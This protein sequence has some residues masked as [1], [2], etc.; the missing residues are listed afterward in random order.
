MALGDNV[1]KS[2]KS[3]G[4]S[5]RELAERTDTDTSY[6]N[7]VETGKV[8]PSVAVLER[9]AVALECSLDQLVKGTEEPEVEIRD[10]GLADR[11]RLIDS[12]DEED[13]H[14][15]VHMIDTMLTKK[16]MR[17][18]LDGQLAPTGTEG[19]RKAR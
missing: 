2:R 18:L 19:A 6:I 4:W 3:K 9:I 17:E 15:L 14:A 13:R 1:R 7:R 8:N 5:Q 10:K 12:L 11:V 16:R